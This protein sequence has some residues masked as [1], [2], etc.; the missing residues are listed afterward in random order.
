MTTTKKQV[1]LLYKEEKGKKNE[2]Q[3]RNCLP[4]RRSL[5][6]FVLPARK[7]TVDHFIFEESVH[8]RA[9]NKLGSPLVLCITGVAQ[10]IC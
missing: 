7:Q 2:F 8:L 10:P 1:D 4:D 6:L 5:H 9:G 3:I